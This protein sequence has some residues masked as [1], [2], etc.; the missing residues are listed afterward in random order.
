MSGLQPPRIEGN[1]LQAAFSLSQPHSWVARFLG[2]SNPTTF[3]GDANTIR[4]FAKSGWIQPALSDRHSVLLGTDIHI[5]AV[6]LNG[7][8]APEILGHIFANVS[9]RAMR[10]WPLRA[11]CSRIDP[12]LMRWFC[13]L[14]FRVWPFPIV[15]FIQFF[16]IQCL[17]AIFDMVLVPDVVHR[18]ETFQKVCQI[19]LPVFFPPCRELSASR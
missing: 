8:T 3:L 2:T 10:R 13:V 5:K 15:P 1:T 16:R 12:A 19:V 6:V 11:M 18:I 7:T 17:D 9:Q 4:L 14:Y